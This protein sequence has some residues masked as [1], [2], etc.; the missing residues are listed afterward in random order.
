MKSEF[1]VI[2]YILDTYIVKYKLHNDKMMPVKTKNPPAPEKHLS[3][4]RCICKTNCETRRCSCRKHGLECNISCG[5]FK[6]EI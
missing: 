3:S 5:E 6:M 2:K 4:I 1:Y